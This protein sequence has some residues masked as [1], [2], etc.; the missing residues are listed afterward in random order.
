MGVFPTLAS[1]A[2]SAPASPTDPSTATSVRS[3][4]PA[5]A[6]SAK[7][8][9]SAER[10]PTPA[11][12]TTASI[13]ARTRSRATTVFPARRGTPALSP[14]AEG[15]NRPRLK[16]RFE[17]SRT[18]RGSVARRSF[19]NPASLPP[20]VCKPRNPCQDGSHNCNKNAN[21]IYL[22]VFSETMFRC[23][24]KPGYAGDG[25]ICGEDSD[26]DGWPNA[27]LVCVENATYNCRKVA[28]P[29]VGRY[30]PAP[31]CYCDNC[32]LNP[33]FGP[34]QDNCPRLPNSGQEDHDKDGLGDECDSDDDNDGIPDDRVGARSNLSSGQQ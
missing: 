24:C 25:R 6:S 12:L 13:A 3:A 28:R 32:L 10:F 21:C 17:R 27:D 9:T 4:T 26:L 19:L 15:W 31:L 11:T 16:S 20:Q 5:T 1:L 23:E 30:Y 29:H 2:P 34:L 7:T 33:S 14:L 22:G 8:S 18:R